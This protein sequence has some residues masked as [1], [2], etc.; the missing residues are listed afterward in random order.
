MATMDR[1]DLEKKL[2]Q[3]FMVGVPGKELEPVLEQAIRKYQPG[4]VIYFARNY[5]TPAL[6]GEFSAALQDLME[7]IGSPPLFLAVD[8]EGGVVQNLGKPFTHFPEPAVLGDLDSPKLAFD[9]ADVMAKELMA[10]GINLNFYPLADIH[11]RP[12]NPIIGRRAFGTTEEVVTRI[13]SAIVRGFVKNGMV[14]SVKHFPGH[15]DTTVDSHKI[16][17]KINQSWE[18]LLEREIKPFSKAIRAKVDMI[19]MAHILNTAIDPKYPA[20]LSKITIEDKL[21]KELRF[22]KLIIADDLQMDAI[23]LNYGADEAAV[24]AI[25]AGNDILIYRDFEPGIQ[26]IEAVKKAVASGRIKPERI[27]ESHARI[28]EV[29]RRVLTPFPAVNIEMISRSIGTEAH[30]KVLAATMVNSRKSN[31]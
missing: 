23:T 4:A 22:D 29:K 5:E 11:T 12:N 27:L 2:G 30:K 20:T 7:E 3:L 6:L 21:R 24:L 19:M 17:P 28:M 10:V 13:S 25:E 14:A 9:V 18:Q 26:A 1:G 31:K 15:G 8:Q 16:L